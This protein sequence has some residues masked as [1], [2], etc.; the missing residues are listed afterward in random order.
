MLSRR[1]RVR[2]LTLG[3]FHKK[4]EVISQEAGARPS[5]F[6]WPSLWA[7]GRVFAAALVALLVWS[8]IA[9]APVRVDGTVRAQQVKIT[10]TALDSGRIFNGMATQQF[11][12][13]EFAAVSLG[14][15]RLVTGT[16]VSLSDPSPALVA[17]SSTAL[18]LAPAGPAPSYVRLALTNVLLDRLQL[19]KQADLL[20]AWSEQSLS[21]T[22]TVTSTSNVPVRGQIIVNNPPLSVVCQECQLSGGADKWE[23]AGAFYPAQGNEVTFAG[24]PT[25][26]TMTF[27]ANPNEVLG[28]TEGIRGV[29]A[30]E[31]L[32]HTGKA[33]IVDGNL[34]IAETG[35]S[36]NLRHGD[37]L[38]LADLESFR[39]QE[40]TAGRDGILLELHGRVGQF[41]SRA[42]AVASNCLPTYF[43]R[44]GKVLPPMF[45]QAL[46]G[47][48]SLGGMVE[49]WRFLAEK[50]KKGA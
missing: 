18:E 17:P 26:I 27:A 25:A 19:P 11:T 36:V 2:H 39:L 32:D 3:R 4:T 23:G 30:L 50:G 43:E 13:Q 24:E 33:S 7:L 29:S 15:G 8:L 46:F 22:L 40:V 28:E 34:K 44:M 1:R 35:E 49:L 48:F 16:S 45:W 6:G 12:L 37:N 31:F 41:R 38:D 42:C 20:L 14:R 9:H 47:L 10:S 5:S 21:L